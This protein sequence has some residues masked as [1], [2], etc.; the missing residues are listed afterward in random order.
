V[1]SWRARIVERPVVDDALLNLHVNVMIS[2]DCIPQISLIGSIIA[3]QL[4]IS[5]G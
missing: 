2:F 1:P 5:K 4:T 3:I